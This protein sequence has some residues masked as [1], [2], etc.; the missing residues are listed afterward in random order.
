[1]QPKKMKVIQM[2]EKQK[3]KHETYNDG[4]IKYGSIQP[5]RNQNKVKIGEKFEEIATLPYELMSIRD[6]DNIIADSLGYTINKKIKVP[7][8]QLPENIKVKIDDAI[9]DIVKKD[10]S[11][12]VNMYLYLQI[13]SNKGEY[14][15]R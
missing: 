4:F 3:L 2:K 10:S 14:N 11:N 9:Y 6:N 8:R 13:A 12:K 15:D 7:Y 1:M 5:I